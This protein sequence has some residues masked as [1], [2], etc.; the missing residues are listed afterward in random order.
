[1]GIKNSRLD[2]NENN[3]SIMMAATVSMTMMSKP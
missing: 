1:M 3:Q 2:E